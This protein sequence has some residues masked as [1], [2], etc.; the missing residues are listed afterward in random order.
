MLPQGN[1]FPA[2]DGSF[3]GSACSPLLALRGPLYH[4]LAVL[5]KTLDTHPARDSQRHDQMRLRA[6]HTLRNNMVVQTWTPYK[7]Y[8]LLSVREL[9]LNSSIAAGRY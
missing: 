7:N 1:R 3:G 9:P 5:S 6:S 8:V 2:V 4:E